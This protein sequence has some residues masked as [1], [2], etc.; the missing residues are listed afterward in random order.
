MTVRECRKKKHMSCE[1][2]ATKM[3]ISVEKYKLYERNPGNM[4]ANLAILFSIIVGV[5]YDDIFF[6]NPLYLK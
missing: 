3:G 2:I 5:S 6:G 4:P 1:T